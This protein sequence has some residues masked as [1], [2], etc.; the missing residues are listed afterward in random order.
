MLEL[1]LAQREAEYLRELEKSGRANELRQAS[2]LRLQILIGTYVLIAV[3]MLLTW[4]AS[5]P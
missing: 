1:E 4:C 3:V 2:K 5:A